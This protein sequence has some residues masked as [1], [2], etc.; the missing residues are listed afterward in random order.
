MRSSTHI[1]RQVGGI[2]RASGHNAEAETGILFRSNWRACSCPLHYGGPLWGAR[3]RFPRPHRFD[4]APA[5][6]TRT[7]EE[8]LTPPTPQP[9]GTPLPAPPRKKIDEPPRKE[10]PQ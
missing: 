1:T 7:T 2:N 3:K 10:R 9:P 5:V 4:C 6:G 8:V